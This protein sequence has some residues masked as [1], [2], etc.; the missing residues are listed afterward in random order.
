MARVV[1]GKFGKSVIFD[2]KK[3]GAIGGDCEA[4]LFF[5]CVAKYNPDVEFLMI[6]R[7]N[8]SK[9][10]PSERKKWFPRENV[11]DVWS[12]A[13]YSDNV[14]YV[15]EKLKDVSIDAGMFFSGPV[16]QANVPGM[17]QT[18][19]SREIVKVL[20]MFRLYVGPMVHY[21][22]ATG[23]PYFTVSPDPRYH[24]LRAR[25][26]F[27]VA[28]FTMSQLEYV[29]RIGVI[30]SYEDQE[31]KW[32][33]VPSHYCGLE[34]AFFYGM[35]YPPPEPRRDR[36]ALSVVMNEA[37]TGNVPKGQILDEYFFDNVPLAGLVEGM[38]V[39]GDWSEEWTSKRKNFKGP[40]Q[41][42]QMWEKTASSRYTM[43][44]PTGR[45][46][47]TAKFWECAYC[48][49]VPFLHPMYD[50]QKW[51][52]CPDVLR[53]K[54]AADFAEKVLRMEEH[55]EERELAVS[56]LRNMLTPELFSGEKICST[57]WRAMEMIDPK[58]SGKKV[59]AADI[60]QTDRDIA[61]AVRK[62]S[63]MSL[64]EDQ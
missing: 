10:S 11:T 52:K 1:I 32:V 50:S 56:N 46:W 63:F 12:D 22:N 28:K 42:A 19:K 36:V 31:L 21:L 48:G 45:D 29:G 59:T 15:T 44:V 57:F 39:W 38:C 7:S 16:G 3:W 5:S 27:N 49:T 41:Y 60:E 23:L 40:V 26:L 17:I 43:L 6:G 33:D 35:Q 18:V 34:N 47:C 62:N 24:P 55:P 30:K 25:D 2:S 54:S 64:A 61:A 9:M 8:M 51:T 14:P 58:F 37:K 20:E 4:P 53:V 13:V